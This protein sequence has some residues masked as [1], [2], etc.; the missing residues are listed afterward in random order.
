MGIWWP[1]PCT[2]APQLADGMWRVSA[3]EAK[4]VLREG[5]PAKTLVTPEALSLEQLGF[6]DNLIDFLSAQPPRPDS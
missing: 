2:C 4:Q 6:A 1:V 3:A 5:C